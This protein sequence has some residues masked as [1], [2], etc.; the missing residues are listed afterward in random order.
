M[1]TVSSEGEFQEAVQVATGTKSCLKLHLVEVSPPVPKLQEIPA[2]AESPVPEPQVRDPIYVEFQCLNRTQSLTLS[3]SSISISV[4]KENAMKA[5]PELRTKAFNFKYTD[6]EGDA[7]TMSEANELADALLIV[8]DRLVLSVSV[9]NDVI[10]TDYNAKSK[11]E[12]TEKEKKKQ[13]EDVTWDDL[14]ETLE[15][16]QKLGFTDTA[17]CT[18]LLERYNYDYDAVVRELTSTKKE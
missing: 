8:N 15:N 7:V 1:V 17:L 5:F 2:Q 16:L 18:R 13:W 12:K 10:L 4:L 3:K 6:D 11:P 14:N 9:D